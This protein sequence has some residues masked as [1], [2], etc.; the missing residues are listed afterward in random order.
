MTVIYRFCFFLF[1]I[2]LILPGCAMR[3]LD[4]AQKAFNEGA[5]I[6]NQQRLSPQSEVFVSPTLSY[7]TAYRHIS[8]AAKKRSKLQKTG[9]LGSAIALKAL[10]EW[11]LNDYESARASA[12]SALQA[13]KTQ[14]QNRGIRMARD[15][16]LMKALPDIL[17]LDQVRSELFA[18]HRGAV[19]FEAARQQYQEQVYNKAEGVAAS[20]EAALNNLQQLEPVAGASLEME[21]YLLL[22]Q[23]TGLKTWAKGIDFLRES[24]TEDRSLSDEERRVATDFFLGERQQHLAPRKA[25]LLAELSVLL[26][27]GTG[28]E[29]YQ[30]W[31]SAL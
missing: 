29:L 1:S 17:V 9:L 28:H 24:I 4:L 10:C 30:F 15:E 20:L 23:L 13:L 8:K 12:R 18:F 26:P 2:V 11:K 16:T 22:V 25:I 7:A 21:A 31:D 27:G 14:E 3:Q 6:E 19:T 5:A